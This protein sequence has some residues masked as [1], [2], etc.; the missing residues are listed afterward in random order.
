MGNQQSADGS[1][2]VRFVCSRPEA[3]RIRE[4]PPD[5]TTTGASCTV[6]YKTPLL[7][8]RR[9]A[10]DILVHRFHLDTVAIQMAE[11]IL[12]YNAQWTHFCTVTTIGC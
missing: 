10:G 3:I 6:P 9:F 4:Y 5:T 2:R 8:V 12:E 7:M 11:N 1:S